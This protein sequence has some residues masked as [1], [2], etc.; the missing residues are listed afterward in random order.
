MAQPVLD[1]GLQRLQPRQPG[2]A[3]A[4]AV[5]PRIGR[6]R[7]PGQHRGGPVEHVEPEDTA[8]AVVDVVRVA[9][10]RRAQG[11]DRL[12]PRRAERGDV[13][14]V[15]PAPGD[16]P[17]AEA[18]VAPRLLADPGED[19]ERVVLLLLRV[20]VGE[21]AVALARA[22]H[23]HPHCRVAVPGQVRLALGVARRGAVDL[24]VGQVLDDRRHG[25]RL[26]VLGQPDA[27]RQARAVGEVEPGVLDLPHRSRELGADPRHYGAGTGSSTSRSRRYGSGIAGFSESISRP[28]RWPSKIASA[29]IRGATQSPIR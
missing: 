3:P 13:Q 2:L 1:P 12:E 6:P 7:V 29:M 28:R 20:L 26:G 25:I 23:V 15:E 22:A 10:V 27:R 8:A 18:A 17:E 16:T 4:L 21:H 11:H 24:A 9:V 14:R 19:L 5:E